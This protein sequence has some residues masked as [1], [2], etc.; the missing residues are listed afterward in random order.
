MNT[1]ETK[2]LFVFCTCLIL[3]TLITL[4]ISIAQAEAFATIEGTVTEDG[5]PITG[6]NVYIGENDPVVTDSAGIY[7][8]Q[9][10]P[11]MVIVFARTAAGEFIGEETITASDGATA[12]VDFSFTPGTLSGI[13]TE[14]GNA[15]AGAKVLAGFNEPVLTGATGQYTV[16]VQSGEIN[17]SARTDAG[18]FIGNQKVAVTANGATTANFDFSPGTVTG[19]VTENESPVEGA[20]VS[21]GLN[22]PVITDAS[23]QYTIKTA[24][25]FIRVFAYSGSEEFI[26]ERMVTL[27]TGNSVTVNFNFTPVTVSGTVTSGSSAVSGARVILGSNMPVTTDDAGQYTGR[28]QPGTWRIFAETSSGEFI[29]EKI[30]QTTSEAPVTGDL[31][32]Q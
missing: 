28:I 32:I 3:V 5:S 29:A 26:E 12:T 4:Q 30:V 23:G 21:A 17:V 11:G 20:K 27:D 31:N 6:T 8:G 24:P 2:G 10:E 14:N 7:S 9:A 25:G 13:V 16:K 1:K 19:V 15:I 22:E 18:E